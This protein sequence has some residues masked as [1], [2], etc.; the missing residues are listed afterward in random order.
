M[1]IGHTE[2]LKHEADSNSDSEKETIH[3]DSIVFS[4]ENTVLDTRM[5][6]QSVLNCPFKYINK[7]PPILT[8]KNCCFVIDGD[9]MDAERIIE[10]SKS[11]W[12]QTSSRVRYYLSEGMKTFHEVDALLCR[13]ELRCAYA[14]KD[15][16]AS[17]MPIPLEQVFRFTCIFVL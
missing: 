12:K 7:Q 15:R 8:M 1:E 9:L 17:I 4:I 6:L 11:W 2:I 3:G 14:R 5:A 16:A 13:G 10:N